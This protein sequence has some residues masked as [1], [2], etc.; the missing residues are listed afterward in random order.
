MLQIHFRKSSFFI[1]EKKFQLAS[2]VEPESRKEGTRPAGVVME[3]WVRKKSKKEV[4]VRQYAAMPGSAGC[5]DVNDRKEV[6]G[7][8][9]LICA[10]DEAG[11]AVHSK[12]TNVTDNVENIQS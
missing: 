7:T 8:L 4:S 10:S 5:K 6:V 9:P 11:E 12:E 3:R 1:L 2:I